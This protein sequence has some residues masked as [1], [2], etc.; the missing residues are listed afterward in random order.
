MLF[1]HD[2]TFWI[3]ACGAAALK[4]ATSPW[5]SPFRAVV[6]VG[7]AIFFAYFFT[8]ATLHQ[9]QLD[10]EVYRNPVAALL[11]LTGEGLARLGLQMLQDPSKLIDIVKAWR[12]GK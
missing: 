3:A 9:L 12:G 5:H 2:L 8:D 1:G 4:L 10:V 6:T 11:A 7:A